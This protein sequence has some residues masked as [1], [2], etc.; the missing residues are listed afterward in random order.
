MSELASLEMERFKKK[1]NENVLTDSGLFFGTEF[2]RGGAIYL[3]HSALW[4]IQTAPE[5]VTREK[6]N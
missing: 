5:N 3:R 2:L 4:V 6:K 1:K